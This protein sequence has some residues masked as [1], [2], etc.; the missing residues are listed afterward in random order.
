MAEWIDHIIQPSD[1]GQRLDRWCKNNLTVSFILIQK[2]LRTGR[3]RVNGNK[4]EGNQRLETWQVVRFPKEAKEERAPRTKVELPS[5]SSLMSLVIHEDDRMFV[6]NKPAGLAVQGGSG[7]THSVDGMLLAWEE[8]RRPKLVHRL[9]RDTSG[10]LVIAR[11]PAAARQLSEAFR[12]HTLDKIYWA[13]LVGVP[14]KKQGE[15]KLAIGKGEE[16]EREKMRV[17]AD[18]KP[19]VSRYKILDTVANTASLV[20]MEP[21]TGRTHQLRV[22]AAAIGHP[23]LGDGKYGGRAAFLHTMELPRQLHLHARSL[24]LPQPKGGKLTV[25]APLP[26]H[27]QQTLSAL[28]LSG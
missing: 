28:G 16:H 3:I 27:M 26:A 24:T 19:S 18:G 9:D 13:V 10:V 17:D 8:G 12:D 20:E 15:I 25:E 11:T 14:E 1:D 22:H 21:L 5:K 6:I 2:W 4:A 23:I 7:I